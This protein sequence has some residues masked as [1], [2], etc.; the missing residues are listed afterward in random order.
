MK[1]IIFVI[2]LVPILVFSQNKEIK[3]WSE[4]DTLQ[5]SDFKTKKNDDG[6]GAFSV[7]SIK[8]TY[9]GLLK[10]MIK[11]EA[12][13]SKTKYTIIDVKSKYILKHEQIHFDIVELF[14]R[15]IRKELMEYYEK[16]YNVDI[17]YS[18][19]IYD[20]FV[21]KF[22]ESEKKYDFKTRNGRN[23]DKQKEWNIKVKNELDKYKGYTN[24]K[25]LKCIDEL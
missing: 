18:N 25:Y 9:I 23:F 14:A 2:I 15:K 5:F 24:E 16:N 11:V 7:V 4:T 17:N 8:K 12:I 10:D 3:F 22:R 6:F 13:F 20:D 21:D 1:K 19:K